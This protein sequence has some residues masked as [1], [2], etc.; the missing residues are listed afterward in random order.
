MVNI[1][2]S[3]LS[4]QQKRQYN[5]DTHVR[6]TEKAKPRRCVICGELFK[7]RR[8]VVR[9]CSRRCVAYL[10]GLPEIQLTREQQRQATVNRLKNPH[11]G[12]FETNHLAKYW[13]LCGPNNEI[14]QFWNMSYFVREH[15]DLFGT[16]DVTMDGCNT[17][18]AQQLRRLRPDRKSPIQSWKGWAWYY[19]LPQELIGKR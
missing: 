5:H 14:H 17:L 10:N 3:K 18:A 16:E 11:T 4:W 13:S 19:A 7:N 9:T 1:W 8:K 15:K 6:L 12:P 2:Y